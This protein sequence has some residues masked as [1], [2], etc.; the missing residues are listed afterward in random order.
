MEKR[1]FYSL[2]GAYNSIYESKDHEKSMIRTELR[3]A[4]DSVQ[5]LQK[6]MKGEGEVEAWIQSKITKAAEYLQ[7]AANYIESGESEVD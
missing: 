6:K 3:V 5:R 7:T 4:L 1:K 2:E